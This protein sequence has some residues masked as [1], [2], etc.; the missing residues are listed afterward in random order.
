MKT[1]STHGPSW[2]RESVT[3]KVVRAESEIVLL[4][5]STEFGN[6]RAPAHFFFSLLLLFLRSRCFSATLDTTIDWTVSV[7][8]D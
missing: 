6:T 1:C 5:E 4:Q 7:P 3:Q 2:L 8:L